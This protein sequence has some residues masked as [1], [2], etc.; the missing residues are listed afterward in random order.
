MEKC[1]I[2]EIPPLFRPPKWTVPE[3]IYAEDRFEH[4]DGAKGIELETIVSHG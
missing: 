4:H 3:A 1:R 2:E